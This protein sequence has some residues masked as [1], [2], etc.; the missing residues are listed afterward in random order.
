[1][2]NMHA[3]KLVEDAPCQMRILLTL[4]CFVMLTDLAHAS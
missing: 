4:L 2:D 1:M 3:Y